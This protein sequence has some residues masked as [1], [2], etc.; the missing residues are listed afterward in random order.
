M[1]RLVVFYF[2]N[3]TLL[4]LFLSML[5]RNYLWETALRRS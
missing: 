5:M 2:M 4:Q 3:L 1:A